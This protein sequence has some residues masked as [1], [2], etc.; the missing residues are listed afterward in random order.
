M[1]SRPL[2]RLSGLEDLSEHIEPAGTMSDE[3][4]IP[5]AHR[6]SG[7]LTIVRHQD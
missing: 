3:I 4:P 1:P 5:V 6:K 2:R 7:F